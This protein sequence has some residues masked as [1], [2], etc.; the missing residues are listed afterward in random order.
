VYIV[1]MCIVPANR[2]SPQAL[3]KKNSTHTDS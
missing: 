2:A 3:E 1:H